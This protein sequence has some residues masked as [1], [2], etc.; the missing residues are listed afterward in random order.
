VLLRKH[1]DD[2]LGRFATYGEVDARSWRLRDLDR[3]GRN[4]LARRGCRATAQIPRRYAPRDDS[5]VPPFPIPQ[6]LSPF[7]VSYLQI[8]W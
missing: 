4:G 2:I 7:T 3:G 1:Q 5:H 8:T 6:T